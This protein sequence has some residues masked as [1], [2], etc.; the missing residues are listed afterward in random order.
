MMQE[1]RRGFDHI[2]FETRTRAAQSRMT[3]HGLDAILVMTEPEVRYFTGFLTPFWQSPTRPWFLVIPSSGKPI[4]V[5]PAIGAAVMERT[6]VDDVR[7][8]SSPDPD[9][10]GISILAD[11]LQGAAST[12]KTIGVP[13]GPETQIRMPL[14]DFERL[15][16]ALP[17]Y[18]FEDATPI[19][20][21]LRMTKSE[22]EIEKI[23]HVCS[24]MSTVFEALPNFVHVGMTEIEIFREFK[25]AAL[26]Q[27]VDDV[28]YLVGGTGPGGLEDII[29]PPS[30][31]QC[32]PGD[33]L[34]LDT[35]ATFDGYFCDFDRNYAFGHA[36]DAAKRAYE[37]VYQ[38]TEAGLSAAR[39]GA[40]CE[41]VFHAMQSVMEAGGALG[42]DVGRLG[43]GLGMQLTEWPS[44]RP[45]DKTELKSGMV[46]TLEPGMEFAPGKVMV[47]E[48]NIVV[49]DGAPELLS[50]RASPELPIIG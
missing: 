37:I 38:A 50:R 5:I 32:Q 43:H 31:R 48:E 26:D 4:A 11:V 40:R 30:S 35:G 49:R 24:L 25:K 12:H 39:P 18:R 6:W 8:W 19:I 46:I 42:N 16:A 17:G 29:S 34:M 10:E 41:D 3:A 7:T 36:D 20:R 22:A 45:G 44:H 23:R 28:A 21:D 9:D 13:M 27:G 33:L 2:E 1:P 14:L 15:K 47:H